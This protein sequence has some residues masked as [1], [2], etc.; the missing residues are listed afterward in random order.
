MSE[1][2]TERLET[3]L[4][5]K[6]RIE[7]KLGEGGMATVYLA[8]DIKHKRKVALKILRPELAAVIG[9]ER[10]LTEITTTANLQHP[11][12]LPLFD[13]GAADGYLYY[14]MPFIDGE[15]LGQ[16]LDREK[17]LGVDEA[18]KIAKEVADALDYAH[19]NGVIHRDIKPANIL[20]HDGRPVVADFGIALAVSA[21]G[22]GR[23][24]ETGLSLGTPH[25]MSPEQ[26]SADRDLSAR[27][28]VYSLGCVLYE[29]IAGQPP[30]TGPSAQSILVRILTEN[31]RPLTE[32]RH[33]VPAHV[34]AVVSKSIEKLPADRFESAGEFMRALEDPT[35]TYE[36]SPPL[37]TATRTAAVPAAVGP[38][39]GGVPTWLA[40]VITAVA[41]TG[42]YALS[43][44]RNPTPLTHP[45]AEFVI[46][47]DS[48]HRL[49]FP[50]C[51]AL[52]A[53]SPLG[54]RVV[55]LGAADEGEGAF[56]YQRPLG[57]REATRTPGT[58]GARQPFFS[59]DGEWVGFSTRGA[60][61][62]VRLD[63][64]A[65]LPVVAGLSGRMAGASW[66]EDD[67]I[68]F[69]SLED[70]HLRR[71]SA[72]GGVVETLVEPD[73]ASGVRGFW[74][75]HVLPGAN[76]VLVDA[77][78][79]GQG[80]R[81]TIGAL[82]LATGE[83]TPVL[84]GG[85]DARYVE[86]GFLVFADGAGSIMAQPFDAKTLEL[87]GDRFRIADRA[88]WNAFEFRSEYDISRT[89]T[90]VI[91][92]SPDQGS[93]ASTTLFMLDRS[94]ASEAIDVGRV[95]R[96]PRFSPDGRYIAFE[97]SEEGDA[98]DIWVWDLVRSSPVRVT[99]EGVNRYPSWSADGSRVVFQR[100]DGDAY[101]KSRDGSGTV[102]QVIEGTGR[103]PAYSRDGRWQVWTSGNASGLGTRIMVKPSDAPGEGTPL[104]NTAFPEFSPA[105][106]PDGRWIAY[107][108]E[109]DGDD[110]VY[111]QPFP[112][113]GARVKVSVEGGREPV[114]SG[115]GR[116]LFFRDY[117][118][119]DLLAVPVIDGDE[120]DFGPAVHLISEVGN[121]GRMGSAT[122]YDVHPDGQRFIFALGGGGTG[123]L[124]PVVI[125]DAVNRS[126]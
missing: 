26:A 14:V 112:D 57:Q 11:H 41:L 121:Y 78:S 69:G 29:M 115:D 45:S 25:Y 82:D 105:I 66:G 111:V 83:W 110:Q 53:V 124:T 61:M 93:V 77:V 38:P 35:F 67:R 76:R 2:H 3:A 1:G 56:L 49:I 85:A 58:E 47:P 33:T 5:G 107:V 62:K 9:A 63:G 113:L 43:A 40:A 98:S 91:L 89:G 80:M 108:G 8:E 120:F 75:P 119:N 39:G 122:A 44:L 4:D 50:C 24:T 7:R 31:P 104:L 103:T 106:S 72:S 68:V 46:L 71:V 117:A 74:W 84:P 94:G 109:D 73:S 87:A 12:I 92:E 70:G 19:R 10:F 118:S 59:P 88:V 55:Y 20:L 30:H 34:S 96:H 86:P 17:Q 51:G 37:A 22:G 27:S 28:D 23:M 60:L 13:S 126:R 6:Y 21:A 116:E 100:D 54:D 99:S 101:S 90:L 97:N 16:K 65:P 18:I 48:S 42:G 81:S 15:T 64:G 125:T 36:P 95:A 114:W 123:L 102:E 79:P 32:M 52:V